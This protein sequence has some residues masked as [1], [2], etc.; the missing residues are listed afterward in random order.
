MKL[1][2]N[3]DLLAKSRDRLHNPTV[4]QTKK[5]SSNT[6][7]SK[8]SKDSAMGQHKAGVLFITSYPPRECGIA[9]YSIDLINALNDKFSSSFNISICALESDEKSFDYPPEVKYI[10][11]T[12]LPDSYKEIA[13]KIN[14]DPEISMV[15]IQHEFGFYYKE[16]GAFIEMMKAIKKPVAVAFHTVLP[17]PDEKIKNHVRDIALYSEY[18]VVMTKSSA[19]ILIN[20][21]GVPSEKINQIAHG[22]HLVTH[23]WKRSLKLKYGLEGRKVLS[24]FGL[25]SSGKGIE[26]SIDAMPAIVKAIPGA[27]FL[28][29]GKTH[30]EVQKREGEKYREGLEQKVK[31]FGLEDNVRFVNRYL[32]LH[33]LLDYLQLTDLYL[34]TGLDPNQAVSGTFVYAMSCACPIISTPIPHAKELLTKDNGAIIDFKN[35]EQLA[36]EAIRVLSNDRLRRNLGLNTLHQIVP[37]SWENSAVKHAEMYKQMAGSA[38]EIQY[39][40]PKIKLDHLTRMTTEVG[41]IQFSK[42]NQPDIKSGYTLDDNARAMVAAGMHYRLKKGAKDLKLIEKYLKFISMCQQPGGDFLNYVDKE[43]QFTEQNNE[44]NL[45]DSNGRAIWALGYITSLHKILPADLIKEASTIINKALVHIRSMNSTRAMAFSVKGLYNYYLALK[46]PGVKPI[47]KTMAQRIKAM[48]QHEAVNGWNWFES[49]LT[50][51]NSIIPEAMLYAWRITGDEEYRKIAY[52]SFDFLLSKIFN[53]RGIEVISNRGWLKK[54]KKQAKFGEQPIDVAYTIM[55]LAQFYEDS[56]NESYLD[57]ITTAFNWF[58]GHNRLN[59]IVYNPCTGG[60]YDGLEEFH[61]NL[62]QGAESLT[63]YLMARFTM[64]EL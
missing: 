30:P 35:S 22:T 4:Q 29:L 52:E 17:N 61:V 63:S 34:F 36:T 8:K 2:S 14:L 13:E 5:Q 62:N 40:L 6:P 46:A 31:E 9:T 59:Q 41:I 39:D 55:A 47:L 27:T 16:E 56:H 38:F 51:G 24:T 49:Y 45:D 19:G 50:Y 53:D 3:A 64:E 43:L 15:F 58:L 25:L 44:V 26:T 48:Y 7:K 10:L 32:S 12:S 57:M 23:K 37:T 18:I 42:L 54:G 11:K 1:K 28:V 21:Y 33:D 20:E 60:C